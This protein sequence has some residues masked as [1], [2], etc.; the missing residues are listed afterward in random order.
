VC[1]KEVETVNYIRATADIRGC[2]CILGDASQ[3]ELVLP[4]SA[5]SQ[6]Q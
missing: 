1:C 4:E 3:R 6:V 2:R 5:D